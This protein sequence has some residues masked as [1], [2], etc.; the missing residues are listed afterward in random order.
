MNPP[1]EPLLESAP[2]AWKI[3]PARCGKDPESDGDCSW[4]HRIWQHLR[5][6]GLAS[7]ARQRGDFYR[8]AVRDLAG[9]RASP[10]IQIAGTADY[11]MLS[12]VLEAL[13]GREASITVVDVCE[14]PLELN[15]WYAA[16]AGR[17]IRTVR[18]NLLDHA[19]GAAYDL[20]CT[21]SVLSRFPA[22]RWPALAASWH[23]SLRPGG[24][25]VTSSRLR[26]GDGPGK[27]GFPPNQVASFEKAV[28][29]IATEQRDRLGIDPGELASAAGLY[30]RRQYNYPVQS[31]EQIGK[32]LEDAGFSFDL[33]AVASGSARNKEGIAAPTVPAGTEWL[34]VVARRP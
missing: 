34:R 18:A 25:L 23:A 12:L 9:R 16:R 31:L 22:A 24:A 13:E 26:P 6:M 14:T 17:Q 2:L 7:S 4:Y 1:E 28:L 19:P 20:I 8:Q 5:I 33:L 29:R 21:D 30:A 10:A 27:I 15:R 32:L 3:A 11:A